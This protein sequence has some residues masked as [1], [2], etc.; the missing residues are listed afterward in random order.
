VLRSK[1]GT[2][3]NKRGGGK[4]RWGPRKVW[5]ANWARRLHTHA[6]KKAKGGGTTTLECLKLIRSSVG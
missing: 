1:G 6:P 5:L 3:K 4:T 2:K